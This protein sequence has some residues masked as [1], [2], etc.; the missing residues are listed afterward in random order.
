MLVGLSWVAV[1]WERESHFE[2]MMCIALL[3]LAFELS[4]IE[5]LFGLSYTD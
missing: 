1:G 3:L 5:Q 4:E 2:D